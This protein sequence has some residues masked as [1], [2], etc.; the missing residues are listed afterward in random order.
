M[1]KRA[2]E[3]RIGL[4]GV[5]A[6]LALA[7]AL[8]PAARALSDADDRFLF[9]DNGLVRVGVDA[10][11]GGSI[12]WLSASG[13]R[14]LVN[15]ADMGREVQLSFY[16]GPDPYNPDDL[17]HSAWYPWPSAPSRRMCPWRRAPRP[18]PCTRS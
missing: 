4:F 3:R 6:S 14:N 12:G 10:T 7:L 18:L 8:S 9:L 17:C 16:A 1:A 5:G 11:R 15:H 2:L 13:G